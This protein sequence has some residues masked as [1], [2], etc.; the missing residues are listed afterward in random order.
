MRRIFIPVLV[1]FL[2]ISILPGNC[3][4]AAD[5][6]ADTSLTVDQAIELALANNKDVKKASL[7]YDSASISN[8]QVWDNID[9]LI[10]DSLIPGTNQYEGASS[11]DWNTMYNSDYNLQ[12]A[13]KNYDTARES[14]KFSVYQKYYAVITALDNSEAKRLAGEQ[15]DEEL[16]ITELRTQLGLDTKLTLYQAQ[17]ASVSA[18]ADYAAAQQALD[19]KYIALM[20]Y[21]G[22][23]SSSRPELVRE[24]SYAPVDIAN[25]ETKF[26]QI[27]SSSPSVWLAKKSLLLTEQTSGTS[28]SQDLDDIDKEKAE[29]TIITTRESM[30]QATRNIYYSILSAEES[31][32]TATEGAKAADEALRVAKLLYDLGMNTKVDVTTAEIAANSAHQ[33]LDS[34]SYQHAILVMALEKPWAYSSGS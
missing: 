31:Y 8:D 32:A 26:D 23:P 9:S 19:Q 2:L 18:Q 7:N 25:P 10:G 5:T 11:S 16:E 30:L 27:V 22:L 12:A 13:Q 1:V 20:E 17:K 6:S 15:A 28:G 14:L 24:L 3:W 4:A 29:L 21:I 33:S 34:L